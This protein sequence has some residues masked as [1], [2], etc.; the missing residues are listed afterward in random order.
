V[1]ALVVFKV[2]QKLKKDAQMGIDYLLSNSS[3]IYGEQ[4]LRHNTVKH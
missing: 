4:G 1:Y 3:A 2:N